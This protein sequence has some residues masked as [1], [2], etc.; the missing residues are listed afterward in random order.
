MSATLHALQRSDIPVARPLRRAI[1]VRGAGALSLDRL[2][3][4]PARGRG[5]TARERA[6]PRARCDPARVPGFWLLASICVL[7]AFAEG[8]FGN[9]AVLYLQNVKQLPEP[10]AASALSAFWAA[11]VGGD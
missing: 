1:V 7:Y 3:A 5:H 4:I 11:L 8:T 9:W 2:L 6:L 10:I